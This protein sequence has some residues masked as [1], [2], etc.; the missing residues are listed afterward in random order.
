MRIVIFLSTI[1]LFS[2][3]ANASIVTLDFESL[4]EGS[5]EGPSVTEDSFTVATDEIYFIVVDDG[6]NQTL[7][8]LSGGSY[9]I[10]QNDG[11]SFDLLSLDTQ[12]WHFD[13]YD[14]S[15]PTRIIGTYAAGG[16]IEMTLPV[17][18]SLAGLAT[19][20]FDAAWSGLASLEIQGGGNNGFYLDNLAMSVVPV[21]AAVWLFG[22]ALAGLGWMRRKQAN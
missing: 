11:Q 10:S 6:S 17:P 4:A 19:A 16:Q 18:G 8:L 13:G 2:S 21:P 3:A 5:T 1:F 22:S 14:G 12:E 9:F 20:N 7:N 15:N